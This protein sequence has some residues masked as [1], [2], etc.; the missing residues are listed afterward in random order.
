MRL[1]RFRILAFRRSWVVWVALASAAT[2]PTSAD[3]LP[4]APRSEWTRAEFTAKLDSLLKRAKNPGGAQEESDTFALA[5]PEDAD[6]LLAAMER[7]PLTSES[8]QKLRAEVLAHPGTPGSLERLLQAPASDPADLHRAV[9]MLVWS[10]DIQ[11][12]DASFKQQAMAQI[13][14]IMK[15]E[16]QAPTN[17]ATA[18]YFASS[19]ELLGEKG[20][21]P[22]SKRAEITQLSQEVSRFQTGFKKRVDVKK[23]D[24][25]ALALDEMKNCTP[26]VKRA[27][28]MT[29]GFLA[30]G[31][32]AFGWGWVS[33]RHGPRIVGLAGAL[34]LG[35]GLVLASRATSLLEFQRNF[36][37]QPGGAVLDGRDVGTVVCPWP[38][39]V[40]LFV[41]A[42]PEARAQ[43][44]FK[45][46]LARGETPIY[47][48]VFADLTERDRRDSERAAA[49]MKPADDAELLD[50][51][52][53]DAAAA[54]QAALAII[55]AKTRG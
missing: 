10:A 23:P 41:T 30:M 18:V 47:E 11:H 55:A 48:R 34:L 44:R 54:F 53:L 20:W 42:S 33:D 52:D 38:N 4:S 1:S 29:V 49:P 43:R 2:A 3:T 50:T 27:A 51:S 31:V 39:V 14:R 37:R 7:F 35:T 15:H 36:A 12:R 46:L 6:A 5:R 40:K 22:Q 19:L 25:L 28:A 16:A 24:Y 13:S 8:T 26:F 17:A 45:E 32:G 9:R 21:V